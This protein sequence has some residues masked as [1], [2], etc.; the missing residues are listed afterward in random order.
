MDVILNHAKNMNFE[1]LIFFLD[2]YHSGEATQKFSEFLELWLIL[3]KNNKFGYYSSNSG[4]SKKLIKFISRAGT[5]SSAANNPVPP[6][7]HSTSGVEPRPA[8]FDRS[9]LAAGELA[10]DEVYTNRFLSTTCTPQWRQLA[11]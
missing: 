10:G 11:F 2:S 5:V 3:Y 1:S 6:V 8:G 7:R 9:V 4:N